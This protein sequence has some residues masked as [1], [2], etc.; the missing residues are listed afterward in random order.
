MHVT[1]SRPNVQKAERAREGVVG[2]F[3]QL[4]RP[5]ARDQAAHATRKVWKWY[6]TRCGHSAKVELQPPTRCPTRQL[7]YRERRADPREKRDT[8]ERALYLPRKHRGDAQQ[9]PMQRA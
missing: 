8:C 5:L 6:A 9:P 4:A 3:S 7:L 1:T 2:G